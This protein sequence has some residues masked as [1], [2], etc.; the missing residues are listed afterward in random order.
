M[1]DAARMVREIGFGHADIAAMTS[2]NPAR[3]LGLS[4]RGTIAIGDRADL[5]GVLT[6]GE[7]AFTMI[8]GE[9]IHA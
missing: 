8:G 6:S 4:G 9:I 1:Q 7:I 3:L 5:V 2:A